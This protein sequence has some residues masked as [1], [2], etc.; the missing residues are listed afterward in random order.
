M[1]YGKQRT[2]MEYGV[3]KWLYRMQ[4]AIGRI[5]TRNRLQGREYGRQ[6]GEYQE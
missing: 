3:R 1:E 2:K 6:K 5:K 4:N